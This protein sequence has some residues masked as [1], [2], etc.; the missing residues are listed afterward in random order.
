[1]IFATVPMP[2]GAENPDLPHLPSK[3]PFLLALRKS[4]ATHPSAPAKSPVLIFP[5]TGP[6]VWRMFAGPHGVSLRRG[7]SKSHKTTR[8]SM[9]RPPRDP[10]GCA[11]RAERS[12]MPAWCAR[13]LPDLK[14]DCQSKSGRLFCVASRAV[15]RRHFS[16]AAWLPPSRIS[17]TF[18]P[19]YSAGRV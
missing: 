5:P 19:L 2:V 13:H 9:P 16:I 14:T 8:S 10:Y 7:C 1:M 3:M 11:F 15:S 6:S 4:L 18:Q 12:H 17:G